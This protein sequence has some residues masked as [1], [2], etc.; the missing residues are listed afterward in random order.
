MATVTAA[1]VQLLQLVA[2]HL[3]WVQILRASKEQ[4]TAHTSVSLRPLEAGKM[5]P[6]VPK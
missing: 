2:K 3:W 5:H 1:A 6:A 4:I